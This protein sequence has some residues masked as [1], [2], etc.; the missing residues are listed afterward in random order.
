MIISIIC[1][2]KG[3]HLQVFCVPVPEILALA[4]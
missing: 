3:N 1:Y 2:L 4:V